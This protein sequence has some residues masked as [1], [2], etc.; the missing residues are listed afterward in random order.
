MSVEVNSYMSARGRA[1]S[2]AG[3]YASHESQESRSPLSTF[4]FLKNLNPDKKQTKGNYS[5]D[6]CILDDA[7]YIC[8]W[9]TAKT[10]RTQA[11][12]QASFDPPSRTKSSSTEVGHL[13]QT[14]SV[15]S[16]VQLTML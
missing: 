4:N 10:S 3:G 5:L 1:P 6:L 7:L 8:R 15:C 9:A 14:S 13:K 12:Q 16:L 2:D 11:R